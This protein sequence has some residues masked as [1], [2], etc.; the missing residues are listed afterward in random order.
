M[1]TIW[2]IFQI[3]AISLMKERS[4]TT[5][6]NKVDRS[7]QLTNREP[8]EYVWFKSYTTLTFIFFSNIPMDKRILDPRKGPINRNAATRSLPKLAK[9]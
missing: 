7:A 6:P 1:D 9:Q 5:E 3:D 4:Q 2:L 8:N